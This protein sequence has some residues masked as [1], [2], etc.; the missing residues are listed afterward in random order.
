VTHRKTF[1]AGERLPPAHRKTFDAGERPPPAHRKTFDASERLPPAHRKTFDAGE[2][3]PPAHRKTFDAGE[4]LPPTHRK[5]FDA[6][7]RLPPAHRKTFD[8]GERLPVPLA[9]GESVQR[10]EKT[11][12]SAKQP[13]NRR[14]TAAGEGPAAARDSPGQCAEHALDAGGESEDALGDAVLHDAERGGEIDRAHDFV[15]RVVR[16]LEVPAPHARTVAR[17]S[18]ADPEERALARSRRLITQLG[19][20]NPRFVHAPSELLRGNVDIQPL[21]REKV[22]VHVCGSMPPTAKR[23]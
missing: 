20:A 6:G 11:S 2:R 15:Q 8:A 9:L 10:A 13:S 5:T 4:R 3:P 12:T 21:K 14:L 19:I 18:L 23:P 17:Q 16:D 22:V 7:E 1:D